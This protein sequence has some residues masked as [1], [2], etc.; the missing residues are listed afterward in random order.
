[1]LNVRLSASVVA[2]PLDVRG[3]AGAAAFDALAELRL[4]SSC[5]YRPWR[6]ASGAAFRPATVDAWDL[7]GLRGPLQRP[8][9][10]RLIA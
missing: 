3:E 8:T 10:Y 9:D 5:L 1:M 6:L 4:V 2:C 7:P